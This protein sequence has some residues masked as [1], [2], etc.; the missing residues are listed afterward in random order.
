LSPLVPLAQ[1]KDQPSALSVTVSGREVEAPRRHL[2]T[3]ALRAT[4]YA[5]SL[6]RT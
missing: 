3:S 5:Q 1:S 2:S 4:R 6:P